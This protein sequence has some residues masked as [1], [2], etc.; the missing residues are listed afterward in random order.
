MRVFLLCRISVFLLFL[1]LPSFVCGVCPL[2]DLG[3]PPTNNATVPNISVY[4]EALDSLNVSAVFDD[5]YFV[6][7]DSRECWPAD[8]FNNESSYGPLFVRLAWHCSGTFRISDEVGGCGG[9]RQRFWPEASWDDNVNLDKARALLAPIKR[10]Y[11]DALSWGDLFVFAG[12]AAIMEMGGPITKVCYGRIDSEN[13]ALSEPLGPGPEAPEC[14]VQG[15][16]SEPLGADTI[17]LIYVNPEGVV[18]ASGTPDPDPYTSA[19]R[20]RNVFGRMGMNDTETVALI[21]GGH[22][23][24]KAHG[25]CPDGPG[26]S[27]DDAPN[28]PWPGMCGTGMAE[29]TYTSGIEGQWTTTPLQWDNDFFQLLLASAQYNL[30]VG[31]GGKFQWMNPSGLM[32]LTTDL[33]LVSDDAYKTIVQ[34]FASSLEALNL[35]FD[36]AWYKLTNSGGVW[37]QNSQCLNVMD[38]SLVSTT[39]NTTTTTETPTASENTDWFIVGIVFIVLFVVA[40]AVIAFLSYMMH[41]NR[42]DQ[43]GKGKYVRASNGAAAETQLAEQTDEE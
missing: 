1:V 6:M 29:D 18:N 8:T 19:L 7:R 22:A 10:R 23:F 16:C 20:I 41:S 13:G 9:G 25:A 39:A 4:N 34:E 12:T 31:V 26:L 36:A 17:G 27:P 37:A 3:T 40:L 43:S 35:A 42:R 24:G 5:L 28:D 14:P 11:G 33:A 32:M 21:G 15:N 2:F 30:T 38:W